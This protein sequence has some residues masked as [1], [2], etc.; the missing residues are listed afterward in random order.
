MMI[1]A[2]I[3]RAIGRKK[4]LEFIFTGERIDAHT[5]EQWGLVNRVVPSEQLMPEA[6]AFCQRL[7][8]KPN[9]VLQLGKEA[10]Y[11]MSDLEYLQSLRYLR[12]MIAITASTEDAAEGVA[13]FLEKRPPVWKHR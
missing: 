3:F 9:L 6:L 12:E 10:F 11:H 2:P 13:A 7:A 1:M 5:A 8:E 4:G